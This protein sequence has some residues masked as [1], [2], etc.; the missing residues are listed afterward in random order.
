MDNNNNSA[1]SPAHYGLNNRSSGYNNDVQLKMPYTEHVGYS[2]NEQQYVNVTPKYEDKVKNKR[3]SQH[4]NSNFYY[5]C[6]DGKCPRFDTGKNCYAANGKK[7]EDLFPYKRSRDDKTKTWVELNLYGSAIAA[8]WRQIVIVYVICVILSLLIVYEIIPP[9]IFPFDGF[10]PGLIFG[11]YSFLIGIY[12]SIAYGNRQ[13]AL[14]SYIIE[15]MGNTID[16]GINVSSLIPDRAIGE[17]LWRYQYDGLNV[18]LVNNTTVW[19]HLQDINYILKSMPYAIKHKYR[20][21]EGLEPKKLPMPTELIAEL[22]AA[23]TCGMDGLD[24]MRQMYLS[25]VSRLIEKGYL[26]NSSVGNLYNKSDN[27]GTSIGKIDYLLGQ[28][29]IPKIFYNLVLVSLWIYCLYLPFAL[30]P[31][32]GL[33]LSLYVYY[34][35]LFFGVAFVL[36]LFNSITTMN[37]PFQ[38]PEESNFIYL[39]LGGIANSVAEGI[40]TSFYLVK[41]ELT[42]IAKS[43]LSGSK[44]MN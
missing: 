3:F 28:A 26:P 36:S 42:A 25:R 39:D 40:D 27:W 6:D 17:M 5:S 9:S 34:P 29:A 11:V 30:W 19:C 8:A 41:K 13:S 31:Y 24:R 7:Y 38:D 23:V 37:N 4:I 2:V 44:E 12:F 21:G 20:P 18:K 43:E 16:T 32:W 33:T 35:A 10:L 14:V 1:W 15:I 22:E